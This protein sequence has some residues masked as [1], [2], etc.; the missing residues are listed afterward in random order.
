[1]KIELYTADLA[2]IFYAVKDHVKIPPEDEKEIYG[3]ICKMANLK[4]SFNC[5]SIKILCDYVDKNV[6][7]SELINIVNHWKK[8]YPCLK[9]NS[10]DI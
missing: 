1:M 8:I 3:W 9:E 2:K 6:K 4:R 5:E 7:N 10:H